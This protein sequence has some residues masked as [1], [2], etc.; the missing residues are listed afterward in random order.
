VGPVEKKEYLV[1]SVECFDF[2]G[3]ISQLGWRIFNQKIF[4]TS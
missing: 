4:K 3:E 2:C 1:G